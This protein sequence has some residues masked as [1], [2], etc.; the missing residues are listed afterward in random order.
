MAV[1]SGNPS[2]KGGTYVRLALAAANGELPGF[3]TGGEHPKFTAF[4]ETS[5][6]PRHVLV[7]V[8]SFSVQ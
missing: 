2:D 1:S 8:S 6:G 5:A 7:G 4:V 3:S